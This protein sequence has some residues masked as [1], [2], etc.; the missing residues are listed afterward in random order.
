MNADGPPHEKGATA[1]QSGDSRAPVNRLLIPVYDQLHA[2]AKA[3]M[4]RESPG[5][6]LQ[7]TALIHEAYLRLAEQH[8]VQWQSRTQFLAIASQA[9]RRILVDSARHHARKKRGG[10]RKQVPLHESVVVAGSP[11]DVDLIALDDAL[12][13]L[14]A[15]A[16]DDAQVVQMRFF[17]GLTI[18]ET[19]EALG[20]STRKVNRM[21]RSARAWLYGQLSKGDGQVNREGGNE[22]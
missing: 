13:R 17:G 10:D 12:T 5:H 7:T 16:P 20:I 8:S 18:E 11:P 14:E 15:I 21:W 4:R 1:R 22:D 2:L 19:A 9:M 3:H 6:T